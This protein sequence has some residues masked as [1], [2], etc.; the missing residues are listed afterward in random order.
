ML[1]P[2]S[3]L[4]SPDLPYARQKRAV[5]LAL[6]AL[7]VCTGCSRGRPPAVE[8]ATPAAAAPAPAPDAADAA[9]GEP[10]AAASGEPSPLPSA[11]GSAGALGPPSQPEALPGGGAAK[12][13]A[14]P[15]EPPAAGRL[16][17]EAPYLSGSYPWPA[18]AAE[19]KAR[20]E[21]LARWNDGGLAE[22]ERWHPAP[23]VVIGEPVV[24]RGKA[25]ARALMRALRAEQ[26]WTVRRCYEPE[27][28]L[29][30]TLEG[31]VVLELSLGRDGVVR[32]ARAVKANRG[33]PD[34]RK[35][36]HAMPGREVPSCLASRLKGARLPA[37][38]SAA[39][40][41]VSI[42]VYPGDAPLPERDTPASAGRMDLDAARAPLASLRPALDR[43][44]EEASRRR[45]GLWGRLALRLTVS[46]A[47]EVAAAAEVESTFPDPAA[48]RCAASVARAARLPAP[49]PAGSGAAVVLAVRWLPPAP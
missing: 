11:S 30:P 15:G 27:L 4:W 46:P 17:M 10:Q 42:D 9:V 21:D 19:R 40:M 25:D 7:L 26:Y 35:H 39:S 23:R 8:P 43:C 20:I 44:L 41:L 12:G 33:V 47:G 3:L 49:T 22:G 2:S 37:P 45:P 14:E 36:G 6:G 34:T 31:R 16:V 24:K 18:D 13:P 32:S 1:K 28:R 38:R 48:A 5:A 29:A